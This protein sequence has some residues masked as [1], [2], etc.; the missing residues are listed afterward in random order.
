MTD[1]A[2][3]D[4]VTAFDAIHDQAQPRKV[5][6]GISAAFRPGGTFLMVDDRVARA[7]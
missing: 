3:F 1:P 5:L 4:L 7:G 2:S 6:A